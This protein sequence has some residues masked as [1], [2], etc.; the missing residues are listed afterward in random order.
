MSIK[1]TDRYRAEIN[2]EIENWI[3][4]FPAEVPMGLDYLRSLFFTPE[5]IE[6]MEEME[7]IATNLWGGSM[8]WKVPSMQLPAFTPPIKGYSEDTF[9][10]PINA[11]LRMQYPP[12][13]IIPEFGDMSI[14]SRNEHAMHFFDTIGELEPK[15]QVIGLLR[16]FKDTLDKFTTLEQLRYVFPGTIFI[17]GNRGYQGVANEIAALNRAPKLPDLTAYELGMFRHLNQWF[18]GMQLIEA[19]TKRWGHTTANHNTVTFEVKPMV[20]RTV[21]DEK[22]YFG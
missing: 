13:R 21:D 14:I 19:F 15:A 10:H 11:S 20:V 7:K 3:G 1:I 6:K 2:A 9:G 5:Q 12:N 4:R 8:T 16:K 22:V 18:A 17:M